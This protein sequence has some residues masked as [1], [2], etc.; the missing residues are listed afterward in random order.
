V[1]PVDE[2]PGAWLALIRSRRPLQEGA[3]LLLDGVIG[4]SSRAI[5]VRGDR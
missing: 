1:R 5:S 3:G 4:W 2:P